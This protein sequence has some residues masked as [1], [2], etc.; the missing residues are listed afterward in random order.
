MRH[1]EHYKDD[2]HKPEM[3]VAITPFEALCSFQP[4]YSVLSNCRATPEL[5]AVV[6]ERLVTELEDAAA[7]PGLPPIAW[8]AD[9][10]ACAV[11]AR[12][13]RAARAARSAAA[14][15]AMAAATSSTGE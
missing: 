11:A 15:A 13:P 6:G 12:R 8:A 7:V 9:F 10:D 1:P 4:A 14:P 3:T 5:V 2:N